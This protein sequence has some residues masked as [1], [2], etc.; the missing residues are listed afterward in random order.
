M[1]IMSDYKNPTS[2]SNPSPERM[3][4]PAY[5]PPKIVCLKDAYQADV[6]GGKPYKA[7]E[8]GMGQ[9]IS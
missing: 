6:D 5:M 8:V 3:A 9:G 7:T 1:T 4:R 2:P